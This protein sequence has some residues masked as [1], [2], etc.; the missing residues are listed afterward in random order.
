MITNDYR[1]LKFADFGLSIQ[2]TGSNQMLKTNC[3]TFRYMAPEVER[4][5]YTNKCDVWSAGCVLFEIVTLKHAFE[6]YDKNNLA[7]NIKNCNV[8]KHL[9]NKHILYDLIINK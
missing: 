5:Q 1:T 2:I 8:S 9:S 7:V 3:G 6:G 4:G